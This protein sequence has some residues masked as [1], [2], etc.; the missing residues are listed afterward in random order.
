MP[1]L[2]TFSCFLLFWV[3]YELSGG[4]DFAPR[5]RTVVSQ[6]PFE[7][8]APRNSAFLRP[9]ATPTVM[10][11]TYVE[12]ETVSLGSARPALVPAPDT[13]T[14][15]SVEDTP[16]AQE[17]IADPVLALRVIAASRVNLREGPGTEHSVLETLPLGTRAEVIASDDNGWAQIRLTESGK[18][19]WM[20]ERLL[21]DG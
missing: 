19:G 17:A 2:I 21:S 8:P 7:K 15:E 20:A 6:A 1:K 4:S 9:T 16:T 5:E 13:A 12:V 14:V 18:I 11:A 3:F 10:A